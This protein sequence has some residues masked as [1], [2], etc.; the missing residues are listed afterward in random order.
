MERKGRIKSSELTNDLRNRA[1]SIC[2]DFK[3]SWV[4][5][6]QTLYSIYEDKLFYLWGFEKFEHYTKT[7]LGIKPQVAMKMIKSY[8]YL[9]NEE[10]AYLKEEFTQM[11]E[12]P[13]V[14]S[15]D[16]INVLRLAKNNKDLLN[17]DYMLLKKGVFEKGKD[18]SVVRKELTAM[19]KERKAVDPEKEREHR[20]NASIKKLIASIESFEKDMESLNLVPKQVIKDAQGLLKKLSKILEKD[21]KNR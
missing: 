9:E 1:L 4:Q 7:E 16:E 19:M 11:R 17:Q 10:P 3:T 21:E 12:G 20:N 2:K 15:L 13:Q 6:G 8:A 5:L 18:A 14:P